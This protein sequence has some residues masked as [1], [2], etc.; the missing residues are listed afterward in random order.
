MQAYHGLVLS[1]NNGSPDKPKRAGEESLSAPPLKKRSINQPTQSSELLLLKWAVSSF[2]PWSVVESKG[3]QAFCSSLSNSFSLPTK[4]G[5]I[6]IATDSAEK[7]KLEIRR[8]LKDA[9]KYSLICSEYQNAGKDYTSVKVTFC[10]SAFQLVSFTLGS[11]EGKC[12]DETVR[13]LLKDYS[14]STTETTNVTL[15]NVPSTVNLGIGGEERCVLQKLDSVLQ[16]SIAA[17]GPMSNLIKH[18]TSDLE[19][20]KAVYNEVQDFVSALS[21]EEGAASKKATDEEVVMLKFFTT[22]L[23]PFFDAHNTLAG[24]TYPTIGLA[25]PVIRRI[26]D[27]LEKMNIAD[28]TSSSMDSQTVKTVTDFHKTLVSK[29]SE[30]FAYILDENPAGM[31]TMPL[32]PRLI[33]IGALSDQE[34]EAVSKI[35]IEKVKEKKMESS[36]P[37]AASDSVLPG[38]KA[39]KPS[40]ASTMGG[41]FWGDDTVDNDA[42]GGNAEAALSYARSNVDRYFTTVKSQRRVEDPLAWW[43][44]NNGDFPELASLAK[45][46]LGAPV[47]GPEADGRT[48]HLEGNIDL[49]VFLHENVHH[50]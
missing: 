2:Q 37:E 27:V 34:K 9:S 16:A 13:A 33:H 43:K 45:V 32:D 19:T 49:M 12:S 50:F 38:G 4:E 7:V 8:L 6:R 41:I 15:M 18:S 1:W 14:L 48:D 21:S 31:W 42:S 11:V 3:I 24:E 10:S 47:I 5:L 20:V 29:F 22:A 44:E 30:T 46:W 35:L 23:R 39:E 25:I 17:K 40:E 36:E 28:L 26:R